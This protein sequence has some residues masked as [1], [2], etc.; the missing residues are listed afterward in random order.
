VCMLAWRAGFPSTAS[1]PGSLSSGKAG[2]GLGVIVDISPCGEE[3][4]APVRQDLISLKTLD[5]GSVFLCLCV[6]VRVVSADLTPVWQG[7]VSSRKYPRCCACA[8][9]VPDLT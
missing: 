5:G 7:L 2:G 3:G 6:C 4:A 1:A 9:R 8:L